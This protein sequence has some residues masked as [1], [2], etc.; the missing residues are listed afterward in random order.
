MYVYAILLATL[1]KE[2]AY[3]TFRS[4]VCIRNYASKSTSAYGGVYV[5]I[6]LL[7][8]GKKKPAAPLGTYVCM[9]I[10]MYVCTFLGYMGV[11]VTSNVL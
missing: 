7:A 5:Y 4:Y 2:E 11:D 10:P 8:R 6:I 9:Y 1:Q 3:R